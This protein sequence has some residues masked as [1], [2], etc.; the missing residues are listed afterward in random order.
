MVSLGHNSSVRSW[1]YNNRVKEYFVETS[2]KQTLRQ[3][4]LLKRSEV[5]DQGE[6][7]Q[8][9]CPQASHQR[10]TFLGFA[11]GHQ[12]FEHMLNTRNHNLNF[13]RSEVQEL[14]APIA[15]PSAALNL[16]DESGMTPEPEKMGDK[17]P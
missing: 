3:S 9:Y 7:W 6:P 15:A 11:M 1:K 8:H 4:E 12:M 13:I 2:T 5:S 10:P 16:V 14:S 17:A